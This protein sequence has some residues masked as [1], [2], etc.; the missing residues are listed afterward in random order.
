[1]S[2]EHG[3]RAP[4]ECPICSEQLHITRLGCAQCGTGLTGA[5]AGCD[6]C[7]L[8]DAQLALLRVF[9]TSRGN[10]REVERHLGVSYPT[11]RARFDDLLRSLGYLTDAPAAPAAEEAPPPE[12]R[13]AVLRDLAA[14]RLD[15][16]AARDRLDQG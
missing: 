12:D 1:M 10:M 4:R 2:P 15:L 16:E 13:L 7:D 11:A 3:Y 14:G 6:F 8:D 9:L 5:F